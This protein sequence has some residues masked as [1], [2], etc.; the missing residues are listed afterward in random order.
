MI[1]TLAPQLQHP[2]ALLPVLTTWA[3]SHWE[4]SRLVLAP[5]AGDGQSPLEG[6]AWVEYKWSFEDQQPALEICEEGWTPEEAQAAV[7]EFNTVSYGARLVDGEEF[8]ALLAQANDGRSPSD[9]VMYLFGLPEGDTA[10]VTATWSDAAAYYF[11]IRIARDCSMQIVSTYYEP[12]D[13]PTCG[14]FASFPVWGIPP[15]SEQR[16]RCR[17]TN[18]LYEFD[19][20]VSQDTCALTPARFVGVMGSSQQDPESGSLWFPELAEH[21]LSEIGYSAVSY[22][23]LTLPTILR[24]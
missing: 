13:M 5:F 17:L 10:V 16:L 14:S 24:V 1:V 22:T 9:K 18:G 15:L 11:Y 20:V 3:R 12:V 7:E 23:H 8:A 6:P 19:A 4:G 2:V 21:P